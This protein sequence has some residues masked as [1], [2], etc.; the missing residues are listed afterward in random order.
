MLGEWN[1]P[2]TSSGSARLPRSRAA[3]SA[4]CEL[5][6]R[7]GEDDL[8]GRVVVGDGDAG[9][10]GDRL[11]VLLVGADEREHRAGVVGLGHQLAAQDDELQ[12]V[13]AAR[14]RRRRRA[15]PA[16]RASG[17]AAAAASRSSAS[18]PARLAQ[19]MAGW[20]KR[21]DSPA[22]GN[23]SS[24]TSAMQRSSSSGARSATRS[25]ISGVWLPWPGKS[26]TGAA[27]S[28]IKLTRRTCPRGACGHS[29]GHANPPAGGLP[30]PRTYVAGCWDGELQLRMGEGSGRPEAVHFS[31][32]LRR[33]SDPEGRKA[34]YRCTTPQ[35][36]TR[37]T[38]IWGLRA[39]PASPT[40][41]S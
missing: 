10:L 16:R 4:I 17:P 15:R 32:S 40:Q 21:V 37:T 35:R 25:R 33:S 28:V 18:Q 23:G 36:A 38:E 29:I 31:P 27:G 9:G 41:R 19:K 11:G 26:A 14:A 12:R 22:R 2:A 13:L 30:S 39:P 5:L 6:A 34:P 8:A 20:A 7:A 24:P 1:A 3:S